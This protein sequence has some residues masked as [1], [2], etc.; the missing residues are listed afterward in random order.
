MAKTL[1]LDVEDYGE[2]TFRS[3]KR[4]AY[5]RF[6]GQATDSDADKFVSMLNLVKSCALKPPPDELDRIFDDC[7]GLVS[8][9]SSELI[10]L[11]TPKY[12]LSVKKES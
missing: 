7:P 5:Q 2:L 10:K 9:L 4:E 11:A 6:V 12:K 3:P 1:T 8:D